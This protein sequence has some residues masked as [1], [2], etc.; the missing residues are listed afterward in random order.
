[1]SV[2]RRIACLSTEAVD[3]L[4]RLGAQHHIAGISGYTVYPPEARQ[5][6]PKISGFTSMKLD[7]IL[8]VQPDLVIGFS[9]L[10]RPLLDEC[11]RAGLAT[12][13]FNHR[14]LAG[15]H[16]MVL[17]L[18]DLVEKEAAAKALCEQLQACQDG[19]AAAA[20]LL[21]RRPRVLFEEWDEPIICG[22]GWVSE[23]IELAGGI[24]IFADKARAGLARDRIVSAEDILARRPELILGS[25]CGKRFV[26]DKV[27]ARPGFAELG[28]RLLEIK[29][30]DILAPGPMAIERGAVQ[31]LAA[32]QAFVSDSSIPICKT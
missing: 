27:L 10:Q 20:A 25:W 4:Y 21:P 24:D 15:I 18:G 6:K 30:A 7:K 14:D 17:R 2:P 28:A 5:E 16:A 31:V 19:I 3:T 22:I 26:P 8:A 32:I 1:M 12:L 11:E 23:I 13:W 29:S 9:D